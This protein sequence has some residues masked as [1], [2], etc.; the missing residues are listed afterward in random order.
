M[1]GNPNLAYYLMCGED[2][3]EYRQPCRICEVE[4][5]K[6]FYIYQRNAWKH[7][8]EHFE[9]DSKLREK[10]FHNKSTDKENIPGLGTRRLHPK[11]PAIVTPLEQFQMKVCYVNTPENIFGQHEVLLKLGN[12]LRWSGNSVLLLSN[13]EISSH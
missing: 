5:K 11:I 7:V 12:L 13:V 9:Q 6:T 8:N 1:S 4:H 2:R 3:R 10:Y